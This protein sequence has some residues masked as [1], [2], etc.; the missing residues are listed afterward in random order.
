MTLKEFAIKLGLDLDAQSFLKGQL[1][2]DALA[3]GLMA[4]KNAVMS[5]FGS[6][7]DGFIGFNA[8]AEEMKMG[9]A[10]II[11]MNLK[12]PFDEAK[13]SAAELYEGLQQ[14]AAATPAETTELVGN[15]KLIA[16]GFFRAGKNVQDLRKFTVQATVAAK[17]LGYEGIAMTDIRQA[18]QGRVG[19]QEVFTKAI[20]KAANVDVDKFKKMKESERAD[21]LLKGLNNETIQSAQKEYESN[22]AGVTS[23]IKDNVGIIV[24]AIGKPFFELLK[25]VLFVLGTWIQ[26]NKEKIISFFL[27]LTRVAIVL[28]TA[29]YDLGTGIWEIVKAL[30]GLVQGMG[31][32]AGAITVVAAAMLTLGVKTTLAVAEFIAMAAIF[33]IIILVLEDFYTFL[34]GGDSLIGEFAEKWMNFLTSWVKPG[35]GDGWIIR[36]LKQAM[37]FLMNLVSYWNDFKSSLEAEQDRELKMVKGVD[38]K[39]YSQSFIDGQAEVD[40]Q[41][42]R[43][44]FEGGKFVPYSGPG[45]VYGRNFWG[46][47]IMPSK[48]GAPSV[49]IQNKVDIKLEGGKSDDETV[50]RVKKA[51]E[52]HHETMMRIAR[53]ALAQ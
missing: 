40:A 28:L 23:T 8:K 36:Q 45:D 20:L 42:G 53:E 52:E 49:T 44:T 14:D 5:A 12:V 33:G 30:A 38:G 47:A 7:Y 50:K 31:P 4:V 11:G 19:V 15:A 46:S 13:K 43:K 26:K 3:T 29:A 22:W 25:K 24:G 39:M 9:L 37:D 1:A 32:V 35:K 16:D 41:T 18:L 51:F 2:A 34:E 21:V 17:M 10:G 48:G 27:N 6:M